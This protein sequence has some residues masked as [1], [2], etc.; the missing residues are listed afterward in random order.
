MSRLKIRRTPER[1]IVLATAPHYQAAL[2]VCDE[3]ELGEEELGLRLVEARIT[4]RNRGRRCNV[5]LTFRWASE[6][7]EE[8][9]VEWAEKKLEAA[10]KL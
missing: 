1:L 10:F 4:T 3:L 2:D 6:L 8:E 7:G 5:T 9:I